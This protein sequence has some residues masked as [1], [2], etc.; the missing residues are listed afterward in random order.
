MG[1][2]FHKL[3]LNNHQDFRS[4]QIFPDKFSILLNTSRLLLYFYFAESIFITK[5]ERGEKTV[6]SQDQI[7]YAGNVRQCSTG[8]D[9]TNEATGRRNVSRISCTFDACTCGKERDYGPR[10]FRKRTRRCRQ[11]CGIPNPGQVPRYRSPRACTR[12]VR[13][14]NRFKYRQMCRYTR[15][16]AISLPYEKDVIEIY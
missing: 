1:G 9:G 16:K 6:V 12:K 5:V 10:L 14:R 8:V 2:G 7:L 11:H 3:I 15:E 4:I 13:T